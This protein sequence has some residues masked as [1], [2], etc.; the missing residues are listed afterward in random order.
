MAIACPPCIKFLGLPLSPTHAKHMQCITRIE[1]GRWRLEMLSWNCLPSV[2]LKVGRSWILSFS[3]NIK[4]REMESYL[5]IQSEQKRKGPS[6]PERLYFCWCQHFNDSKASPHFFRFSFAYHSIGCRQHRISDHIQQYNDRICEKTWQGI[7]H[8][9][10]IL[11]SKPQS[12]ACKKI[13]SSYNSLLPL[14][15]SHPKLQLGIL[16]KRVQLKI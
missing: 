6:I 5:L 10:V 16:D 13:C 7:K 12:S 1:K 15:L 8:R 2:L 3:V 4:R 9:I 14:T 11:K